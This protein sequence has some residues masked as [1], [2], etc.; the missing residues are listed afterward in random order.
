MICGPLER[1]LFCRARAPLC[2]WQPPK[3]VRSALLL[4]DLELLWLLTIMSSL[5][6]FLHL[7]CQLSFAVTCSAG[8]A[9]YCSF[10]TWNQ[11]LQTMCDLG[12]KLT[13]PLMCAPILRDGRWWTVVC[14]QVKPVHSWVATLIFSGFRYVPNGTGCQELLSGF[15]KCYNRVEKN[16][17]CRR[18]NNRKSL[19]CMKGKLL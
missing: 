17:V 5:N 9:L 12:D 7:C 6:L 15:V 14:P 8:S 19:C 13:K 2:S 1:L 16:W 11:L 18:Q 3:C 4:V 10:Y